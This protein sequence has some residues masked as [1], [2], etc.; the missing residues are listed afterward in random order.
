MHDQ[1]LIRTS[2][3]GLQGVLQ[4]SEGCGCQGGVQPRPGSTGPLRPG[5]CH[6]AGDEGPQHCAVHGRQRAGGP[7]PAAHAVHA[8]WQPLGCPAKGQRRQV[9]LVSR[10]SIGLS[11]DNFSQS[12]GRDTSR[13][14]LTL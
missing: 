6:A 14:W 3:V 5:D 11:L 10:V 13:K 7:H 8:A 9:W 12:S 1:R 4:G 2:A